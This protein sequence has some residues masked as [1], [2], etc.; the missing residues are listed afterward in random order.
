MNENFKLGVVKALIG[1]AV[2]SILGEI[3]RRTRPKEPVI[4]N[5]ADRIDWDA[6][7]KELMKE[8]R[9][10]GSRKPHKK[11]KVRD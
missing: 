1:A 7:Y 11:D 6:E 5:M 8:A 3:F 9:K 10:K 2:P 4:E